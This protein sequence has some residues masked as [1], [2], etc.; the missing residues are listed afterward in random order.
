MKHL[1]QYINI[2]KSKLDENQ[3]GDFINTLLEYNDDV[4][5]LYECTRLLKKIGTCELF[6]V[7]TEGIMNV[8]KTNEYKLYLDYPE[9]TPDS[10]Y[11]ENHVLVLPLI[12][13]CQFIISVYSPKNRYINHINITTLWKDYDNFIIYLTPKTKDFIK[14]YKNSDLDGVSTMYS[15]NKKASNDKY[16]E[17]IEALKNSFEEIIK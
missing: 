10:Y 8:L 13:T 4:E 5:Q 14:M 7:V 11:E 17:C 2:K 16:K 3:Y 9:S 12:G 6:D 1:N 15:I